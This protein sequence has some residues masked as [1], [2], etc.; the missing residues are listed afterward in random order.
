M[1]EPGATTMATCSQC[2]GTGWRQV[3]AGQGSAVERCAC[4][5]EADRY[6]S[7]GLP[8]RLQDKTFD[9]FSAGSHEENKGIYDKFTR[10]MN[11]A[12]KFGDEFPVHAKHGILLHGG[13]P[14]KM[15][16]LAVAA[17]KRLAKRGLDCAFWDYQELLET[18]RSGEFD[19]RNESMRLAD[20]PDVLLLDCMGEHRPTDWAVDTV[21]RIVKHRYNHCKGL[22]VTTSFPIEPPD[23][24]EPS[25]GYLGPAQGLRPRVA[26][27][28]AD[29]VGGPSVAMLLEHCDQIP[30]VEPKVTPEVVR[31]PE[32]G[33]TRL[34]R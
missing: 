15:T 14:E 23:L 34:P 32:T 9:N 33:A 27:T 18:L 3:K 12:R 21:H 17:L 20:G 7:L 25:D 2:Q 8:R 31:S 5:Q 26:D 4:Y 30:M 11:L 29:R 16:H 1:E 22:I 24:P 19:E 13:R 28:L 6:A 10:A